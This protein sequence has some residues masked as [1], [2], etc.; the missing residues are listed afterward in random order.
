M[1][2]LDT[3]KRGSPGGFSACGNNSLGSS[4]SSKQL[5]GGQ[6]NIGLTKKLENNKKK[7]YAF[8][9]AMFSEAPPLWDEKS[10]R[11]L[12]YSPELCPDTGRKH[13]QWYV[14]FKSQ[15]TLSAA[16]KHI[17]KIGW[18]PTTMLPSEGSPQQNREYCGGSDYED[19]D[20]K[21]KTKNDS[22]VEYGELPVKGRRVD[23]EEIGDKILSGE[24]TSD[25]VCCENKEFHHQYG[26]TCDRLE[27]IHLRG[28]WRKEM[29]KGHWICGPAG[30]GK[31]HSA[32]KD[33]DPR[34][35]YVLNTN[36]NGWWEGYKQ[37]E[38]V[39]INDFRGSD[40]K[41]GELLDLVDKWP[42]TVKRRGREPMPFTSKLVIITSSM[43]PKEAYSTLAKSDSLKQLYDR[44][45]VEVMEGESKRCVPTGRKA[46]ESSTTPCALSQEPLPGLKSN[47]PFES[48]NAEKSA[49]DLKES[50]KHLEKKCFVP[51]AERES[52]VK[53]MI[54]KFGGGIRK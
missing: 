26:R 41:Y 38:T 49:P 54:S 27:D 14:Y 7:V 5:L 50:K 20:G 47:D 33:F 32:F 15:K 19:K 21:K 8:C 11:Y 35:H 12:C 39:I 29:T 13:W 16:Q 10:M 42:K 30:V 44:F 18:A 22:F 43:T 53:L 52:G 37:Q 4:K 48:I 36:D 9:A 24:L 17:T 34:T 51:S 31:S 23:I 46:A 40:M 3:K 25:E 6:G 1:N 45:F 28:R 2:A